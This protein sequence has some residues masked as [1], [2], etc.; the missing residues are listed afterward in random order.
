MLLNCF[1]LPD[2]DKGAVHHL[3]NT[4]L[5]EAKWLHNVSEDSTGAFPAGVH[6]EGPFINRDKKGAHNEAFIRDCLSPKEV[7]ACYG[8]LA[9]VRIVTLAP[10]LPGAM[11]TI[12]WL[13][14]EKKIVVSLGVPC[15]DVCMIAYTYTTCACPA[16]LILTPHRSLNV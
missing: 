14:E 7:E 12:R 9:Y 2:S 1:W 10:E 3:H 5:H 15:C 16:L 4:L 11:E 13:T 8:D 6:L